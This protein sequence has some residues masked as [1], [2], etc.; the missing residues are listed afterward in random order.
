MEEKSVENN[1]KNKIIIIVLIILVL[2]VLGEACYIIFGM[3]DNK[4]QDKNEITT[5]DKVDDT[6][7]DEEVKV[8][9]KENDIIATESKNIKLNVKDVTVSLKYYILKEYSK[10][11]EEDEYKLYYDI[12]LNDKAVTNGEKNPVYYDSCDY[13]GETEDCSI[14]KEKL[15]KFATELIGLKKIVDNNK[16][17][18]VIV[19]LYGGSPMDSEKLYI[20]DETGKVL[21]NMFVD[22]NLGYGTITGDSKKD[23]VFKD[24]GENYSYFHYYVIKS[25]KINYLEA[26]YRESNNSRDAQF[27]KNEF[28]ENTLTIENG[29]V[30]D[31]KTGNTLK[32]EGASGG[33]SDFISVKTY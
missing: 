2:I 3:K 25:D 16:K 33:S 9:V 23:Y 11:F 27:S 24:E 8:D 4:E 19:D 22:L 18:Y 28:Y 21:M 32:A 26:K 1:N 31:K 6:K 20:I 14:T 7:K 12:Y 29:K 30:V 5:N 10:E 13:E 17:E 15:A